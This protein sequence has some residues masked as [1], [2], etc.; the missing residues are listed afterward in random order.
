MKNSS[1]NNSEE[2]LFFDREI[3][4]LQFNERVLEQARDTSLPPLERLKFL[5]ICSSNMDEFFEI[6]VG[7]LKQKALLNLAPRTTLKGIRE[8]TAK[9]VKNQ[10]DIFNTELLPALAKHN[11]DFVPPKKWTAKQETWLKDYFEN[12]VLPVLSPIAL[13]PAHPMPRLINKSLN[14][15]VELSGKDAFGRESQLAIVHAPRALPRMIELPKK[16]K[17]HYH[18]VF[19]SDII[20]NFSQKLFPGLDIKGCYQ[21]RITRNSDL[22]LEQEEMKDLATTVI[23]KLQA[24]RY[25]NAVRL[26]IINDCPQKWVDYLLSKHG[27]TDKEL[28]VTDGP[29]NL[30]RYL[31]L[32]DLIDRPDL[33]YPP[34]IPAS[35]APTL[36]DIKKQDLLLHHPYETFSAIP[37]LIQEATR[38]PNV[39]A[40][41]QTLYRTGHDSAVA[42]VLID[43]A[44]AGKEVTAVI[45]LRARFDEESNVQLAN[46]LQEAGVL[47]VY[48]VVGFKTH[49]KLLLIIRQEDGE[50]KRYCHLGTGNYHAKTAKLYTD[51]GL[52]TADP[53]IGLD[54]QNVFQ[55][56]TGTG[57]TLKLKKLLQAPF[58]L[59]DK[60]VELIDREIYFARHKHKAHIKIKINALTDRK[61]IQ[62]LYEASQEGVKIDLI[63]RGMCCL[64]PG[65]KNLSENI[66][67]RSIIGRFLEH[68]RVFYFHNSGKKEIYCSS[69]DLMERNLYY[70]IEVC[71]PILDKA[72]AERVEQESLTDFLSDDIIRWELDAEG[73]YHLIHKSHKV[74]VQDKL[75]EQYHDLETKS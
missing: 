57:K 75:L 30:S 56:L 5:C 2:I 63:V 44:R 6:R 52:L 3:S 20:K 36:S 9:L 33:K 60:L 18:F 34:F 43:A 35:R 11:I 68:E 25:G 59:Y 15:L 17:E 74:A 21:F 61:I 37:H 16:N 27:L 49:A 69:A 24:L 14:F 58:N 54:V 45:E 10:Y 8:H 53:V 12:H 71:F 70:R 64:K 40:I 42:R 47:V 28:Y 22:L 65:I 19:L 72:L 73:Q 1:K 32:Y 38:D 13:D 31:E 51:Y 7:S 46:K 4:L 48:G 55:Q 62:H 50:L 23:S 29:V 67:V 26:E 39:I 41:K 66:T